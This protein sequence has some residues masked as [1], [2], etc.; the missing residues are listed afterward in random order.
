VCVP[1][2][3]SRQKKRTVHATPLHPATRTLPGQQ[4]VVSRLTAIN[5]PQAAASCLLPGNNRE[6][7][8][9]DRPIFPPTKQGPVLEF[10]DRRR[11]GSPVFPCTGRPSDCPLFLHRHLTNL[12]EDLEI[13][14]T[15]HLKSIC[16]CDYG[17]IHRGSHPLR[18]RH[19]LRRASPSSRPRLAWRFGESCH[20]LNQKP[21]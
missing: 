4:R 19:Q 8:S 9:V 12:G 17:T 3:I 15:A 20:S 6:L 14:R 10:P 21:R 16:A 11:L 1:S 5:R 13:S 18:W 2:N 7:C